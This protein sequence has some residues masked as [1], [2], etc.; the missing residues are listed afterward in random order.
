MVYELYNCMY[1]CIKA[2]AYRTFIYAFVLNI[3]IVFLK[4]QSHDMS[5]RCSRV[6]YLESVVLL[7]NNWP[8]PSKE[9]RYSIYCA[10]PVCF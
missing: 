3:S 10:I 1:N 7:A 8:L 2:V 9:P 6:K 5:Y 4:T